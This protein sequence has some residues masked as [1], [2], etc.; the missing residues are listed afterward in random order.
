MS[1]KLDAFKD[2]IEKHLRQRWDSQDERWSVRPGGGERYIQDKVL[3]KAAPCLTIES[4]KVNARENLLR[5]LQ[6][7]VNL[8][9]QFEGSFA[10]V[11]IQRASQSMLQEKFMALLYDT[12]KPLDQR[13][14]EFLDWAKIGK[15]PEEG[16]K[17]GIN[18]TVCSYFL[19]MSRPREY[20]YC[21]PIA[22]NTIVDALLS[23]SMRKDN[24]VDRIIHCQEIYKAIL[25]ILES[26]Y[27]LV[28]GNLLDVHSLC[29]MFSVLTGEKSEAALSFEEPTKAKHYWTYAPGGNAVFWEEFYENGI[30]AIGWDFLG[31]LA[32]YEAKEDIL[33]KISENRSADQSPINAALACYDFSKTMQVGDVV[34]A[35]RGAKEIVGYGMVASDYYFDANRKRLQH[36]RKIKW[37][38]KG[39]WALSDEKMAIKTLTDITAYEDFVQRLWQLVGHAPMDARSSADSEASEMGWD[40][41]SELPNLFIDDQVFWQIVHQLKQKKNIILQGPPGVGKTFRNR[42]RG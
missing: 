1:L 38:G 7:H 24:P 12:A 13:I 16:K 15:L 5:A 35:K 30:M 8:L 21:K 33:E 23:R 27:G 25:T 2:F 40:Y 18:A 28:E 42:S 32:G 20:P 37:L 29:Y 41:Q 3:K 39:S 34:F 6:G 22:Y 11:F 19:A 36:V 14:A 10:R 9:S 31:D 26:E 17:L 4:L